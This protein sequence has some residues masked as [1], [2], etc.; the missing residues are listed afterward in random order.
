MCAEVLIDSSPVDDAAT[1]LFR[2]IS[3]TCI[4]RTLI[5][6]TIYLTLIA[7]ATKMMKEIFRGYEVFVSKETT[8]QNRGALLD[9][10]SRLLREKGIDGVGVAEIAKEAGLTHGALYKHFASKEALAAEAFYHPIAVR[11]AETGASDTA[12]FEQ[13]LEE[14][15]SVE[16]RD[17]LAEGCPMTASASEIARQGPAVAA[18]FTRAFKERVAALEASIEGKMSVSDKRQLAIAALAAQ[19][20]AMAVSRAAAKVD[21]Q[22]SREVL[23][24]VRQTVRPTRRAPTKVKRSRDIPSAAH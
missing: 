20:G 23:Q 5:A 6:V 24:A 2:T 8:E 7:F 4:V 3:V 22:F 16:H 12:S 21:A 17:N 19:I 15:F 18:S 14:M 9:A 10:A 11:K 1:Y 13:Y